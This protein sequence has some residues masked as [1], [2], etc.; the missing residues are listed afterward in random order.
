M[1][2][3]ISPRNFAI[4]RVSNHGTSNPVFARLFLQMLE[5]FKFTKFSE[6]KQKEIQDKLYA[7]SHALLKCYDI[8]QNFI[9]EFN[10]ELNK[11]KPLDPI[12]HMY[13]NPHMQNLEAFSENF[14]YHAKNYLRDLGLFLKFFYPSLKLPETPFSTKGKK[15][16]FNDF[17][18][19]KR[20]DLSTVFTEDRIWINELISKRNSVEHPDGYNGRLKIINFQTTE[21]QVIIPPVWY[22]E[23][24]EEK[25]SDVTDI[26]QD[27]NVWVTNLLTFS[28]DIIIHFCIENNFC[29]EGIV[30][31]KIPKEEQD[32]DCP[33]KFKVTLANR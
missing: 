12:T 20:P 11:V 1:N 28:E 25:L 33:I 23:K 32:K 27:I 8:T 24:N 31:C 5:L 7:L 15:N 6:D 30:I 2:N 13:Y 10:K 17:L 22:R 26:L 9:E 18:E 14:L 16:I 21:T 4:T 19:L 29:A 3:K